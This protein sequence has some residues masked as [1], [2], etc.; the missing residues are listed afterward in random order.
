MFLL[1]I[2]AVR[3]QVHS[4]RAASYSAARGVDCAKCCLP[5]CDRVLSGRNL[6]TFRT[7]VQPISK[8]FGCSTMNMTTA[9][10]FETCVSFVYRPPGAAS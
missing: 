7:N 3:H 4:F 2:S 8:I 9:V 5:Q 6:S 1:V 10:Y